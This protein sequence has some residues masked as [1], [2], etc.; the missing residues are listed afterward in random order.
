VNSLS[1][2][3]EMAWLIHPGEVSVDLRRE[4]DLLAPPRLGPPATQDEA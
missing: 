2:N 1:L 3:M 4:R